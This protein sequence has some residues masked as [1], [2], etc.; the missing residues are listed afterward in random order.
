MT[1]ELIHLNTNSYE[2][3]WSQVTVGLVTLLCIIVSAMLQI[4]VYTCY[5]TYTVPS[6]PPKSHNPEF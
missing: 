4:T 2:W 1:C 3:I 5:V 6:P